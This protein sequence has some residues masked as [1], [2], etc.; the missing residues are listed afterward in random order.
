MF[1]ER[2]KYKGKIK[3]Y[4]VHSYRHNGKVKKIRI[5]LGIDLSK[6]EL[7]EKREHAEIE[8]KE[9]IEY[10]KKIG[11][12]FTTVLSSSDYKELES[13]EP[14][15]KIKLLHLSEDDWQRFSEVFTYDTNAIE[16]SAIDE[17]EVEDILEKNKWPNKPKEEIS[18]TYGV[19]EAVK[20][21]RKSKEHVSLKLIKE[22]HK[23]I[24]KN[25][26]SFAGRFREKGTEVVVAD[27]LGNVIHRGAPSAQVLS[28]LKK[29]VDW[30]NKNKNQ[31]P[32]LVL[33]AIVH[34]QFENIHPF[35]DGNGRVGRLL[36]I[37]ILMKHGLP[38]LNIELKNRLEYY[39]ALQAYQR[40]YNL[41]PMIELMLKEYKKLKK[42]FAKKR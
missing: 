36:L 9:K 15:G 3:Y 14:N 10:S 27:A 13:L 11:D 26:K 1:I 24:F 42:I 41:R 28:S 23:I 5:Y 30:Y 6:K 17:K 37:N 33:A 31:Y 34:N 12:P 38:P 21:L 20:Y 25:S 7:E 2:R 29:L 16:G 19:A 8:I 22:L 40:A 35:A 39:G 18:E 4:L 32:P